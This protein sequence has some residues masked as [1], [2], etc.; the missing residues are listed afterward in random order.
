MKKEE[1]PRRKLVLRVATEIGCP[2][3]SP[4]RLSGNDLPPGNSA[5]GTDPASTPD[6]G[7]NPGL[8]E[9]TGSEDER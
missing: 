7:A 9:T 2:S 1:T 3:W 4:I 5:T 8:T 6:A